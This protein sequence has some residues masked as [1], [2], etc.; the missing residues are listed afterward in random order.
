MGWVYGCWEKM[1]AGMH[2]RGCAWM[3][4]EWKG[5]DGR[6][7]GK[8]NGMEMGMGMGGGKDG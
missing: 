8:G 4:Y 2:E 7:M 5:S 1:R 6:V 3:G